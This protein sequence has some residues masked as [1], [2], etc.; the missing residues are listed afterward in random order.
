MQIE[1]D[2]DKE[3]HNGDIGH[4]VDVDPET[5]ELGQPSTARGDLLLR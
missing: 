2:Y 3:V 5:D 4:V 1:N